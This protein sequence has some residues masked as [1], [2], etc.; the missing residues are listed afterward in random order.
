MMIS[1]EIRHYAQTKYI[2]LNL[3]MSKIMELLLL[4]YTSYNIRG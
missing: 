3:E 1:C 2:Q 4:E